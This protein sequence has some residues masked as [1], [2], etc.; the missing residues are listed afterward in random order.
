MPEQKGAEMRI[1]VHPIAVG[2]GRIVVQ[3]LLVPG[4]HLLEE[5]LDVGQQRRLKFVDEDGARG[6]AATTS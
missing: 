2:V 6:C 5:A 1:R 4:H 3:P